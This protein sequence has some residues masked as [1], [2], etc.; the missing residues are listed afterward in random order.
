MFKK[1]VVIECDASDIEELVM[2]HYPQFKEYELYPY[3]EHD[4]SVMF[5]HVQAEDVEDEYD[6]TKF[7]AGKA[8]W[9]ATVLLNKLC[10]DGHIEPGKYLIDGTW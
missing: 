1:K 9:M 3:E 10:F 8:Q 5:K 6:K 2:K 7:D 4:N